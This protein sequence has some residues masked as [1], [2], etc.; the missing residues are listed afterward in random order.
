M[1]I[2][3]CGFK[4]AGKSSAAEFVRQHV[5]ETQVLSFAAPLKDA[6]S[7]IFRWD[8]EMLEGATEES[9]IWREQEDPYWSNVFGRPITP[10]RMMQEVGTEVFRSF[11]SDVWI[12]SLTKRIL[13]LPP[14]AT[15]VISDCRFLNEME[16]IHKLGGL[17]VWVRRPDTDPMFPE[18]WSG[19][20]QVKL[21]G[22]A[23]EVSFLNDGKDLIDI[24]IHNNGSLPE[25]EYRV[26]SFVREFL[27]ENEYVS[28]NLPN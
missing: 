21:E 22:H 5:P 4:N 19:F 13:E 10:R 6:L 16:A 9:R 12:A 15:V 1:V 17:I 18:H 11:C 27:K 25:L 8:R 14:T 2:G 23:S 20:P 28:S 7:A 24:T 3:F 26:K